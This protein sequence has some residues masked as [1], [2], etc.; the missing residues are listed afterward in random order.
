MSIALD[1]RLRGTLQN[2][3]AAQT[4]LNDLHRQ[5]LSRPQPFILPQL[6]AQYVAAAVARG[7]AS[8]STQPA[9]AQQTDTLMNATMSN[10]A[11]MRHEMLKA[12]AQNL[13]G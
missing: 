3:S 9:S 8:V 10:L 11:N 1:P 2:D 12:V 6:L 4:L 5:I 7:A 13:R